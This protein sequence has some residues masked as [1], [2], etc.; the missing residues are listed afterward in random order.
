MAKIIVANAP[1]PQSLFRIVSQSELILSQVMH[2]AHARNA[3]AL[4]GIL[5]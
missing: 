4:Q 1:F 5:L 3:S 2:P